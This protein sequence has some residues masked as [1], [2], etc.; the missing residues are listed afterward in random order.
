VN[1]TS[2]DTRKTPAQQEEETA[3]RKPMKIGAATRYDPRLE[4]HPLRRVVT[5]GHRV[6]ETEIQELIEGHVT[7]QRLTTWA[8]H[9]TTICSFYSGSPY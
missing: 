8:G 9:D 5:C 3:F 2:R 4:S 1:N 7:I 6:G